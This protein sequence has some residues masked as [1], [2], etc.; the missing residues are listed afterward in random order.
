ML[1]DDL[2]KVE[3]AEA[4]D[5]ARES[6]QVG[7]HHRP[8][9][10]EQVPDSAID[11]VDVGTRFRA[12]LDHAPQPRFAHLESFELGRHHGRS[13]PTLRFRRINLIMPN[14]TKLASGPKRAFKLRVGSARASQ[15]CL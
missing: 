4:L 3:D 8:V 6:R 1:V 12:F 14:R 13:I 7:E 11:L 2:E 5:L 15:A 10:A 9:L